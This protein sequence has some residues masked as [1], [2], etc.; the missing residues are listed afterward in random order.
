MTRLVADHNELPL[1]HIHGI[2]N[3]VFDSISDMNNFSEITAADI[4][5]VCYVSS[6][7]GEYFSLSSID[8]LTGQGIWKSL[9]GEGG[10]AN[11][12]DLAIAARNSSTLTITSS[13]G[14]DAVVP[15]A[16]DT[17]AGLFTATE[18]VKLGTVAENATANSSD[19]FL[20]NRANHFGSQ[21]A[22][23]ISDFAEAA[24]DATSYYQE[25]LTP[26]STWTLN[27]NLGYRPKTSVYSVGGVEVSAEVV[28]TSD[29]QVQILFDAPFAGYAV[30][31]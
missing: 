8:T 3:W 29:N 7:E 9:G 22:S 17:L 14:A 11:T 4:H 6:G 13:N 28:H 1:G 15:A 24:I 10:G 16:T 31:S 2:A 30:C 25:E 12:T 19:T 27:H 5:K 21:I 23:T 18:K 20:R 26:A